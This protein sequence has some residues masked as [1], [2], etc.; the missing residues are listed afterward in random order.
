MV[1]AVA[2]PDLYYATAMYEMDIFT[3]DTLPTP[4]PVTPT[5]PPPPALPVV[6]ATASSVA[7][8]AMNAFDGLT[9]SYWQIASDNFGY[10]DKWVQA[11]LGNSKA[12]NHII[13]NFGT[14]NET[15]ATEFQSL[16]R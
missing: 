15:V 2:R 6:A 8:Q 9:S 12:L 3:D 7:T 11:D 5:P 10:T 16:D 4:P 1:Y 13:V 14:A